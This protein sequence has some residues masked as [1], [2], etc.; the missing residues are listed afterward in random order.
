MIMPS[1]MKRDKCGMSWKK[2]DNCH[3][4]GSRNSRPSPSAVGTVLV[5]SLAHLSIAQNFLALPA[6]VPA[7]ALGGIS[8]VLALQSLP[9]NFIEGLG[10]ELVFFAEV[11]ALRLFSPE[12][13][14]VRGH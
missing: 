5:G 4:F 10:I 6:Q 1:A 11:K 9:E 12:S 8:R 14:R 13:C 2:S 7:I 3:F